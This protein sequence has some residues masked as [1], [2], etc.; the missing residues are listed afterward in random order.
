M[1]I[2]ANRTRNEFPGAIYHV[3][4][5]GNNGRKIFKSA[6]DRGAFLELVA[7]IAA[8]RGWI[9]H[10]YCLMGNHYHLLIETPE[11]DLGAGMR[12][13]NGRYA[14]AFN[15][16]RGR[17]EHLFGERYHPELVRS[18]RHLLLAIRYIVSNPVVAGLCRRPEDWA[19]SSFRAT[20]GFAP[21]PPFLDAETTL[22]Y[23][24]PDPGRAKELFRSFVGEGL[25]ESADAGEVGPTS[26]IRRQSATC[27]NAPAHSASAP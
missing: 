19:W 7:V 15:A 8:K 27:D 9:I 13:L 2:L 1:A 17:K 26:R 18:D 14:I 25:P 22:W 10:A 3:T 20:L 23:F 21:T 24:A 6:S 16:R 4:A 11:P 12:H 5:R